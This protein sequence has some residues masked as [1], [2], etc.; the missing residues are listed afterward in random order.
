MSSQET[1]DRLVSIIKQHQLEHGHSKLP[2]AKLA[3]AAG[4]SR[5][6][7]NRYYGDLK[8]YSIGKASIARLFV[9]DSA[10][11]NELIENKDERILRLERELVT[12]RE[13]HKAELE[14]IVKN[15]ISTLMNTDIMAFEASQLTSTLINQ[16]NH[17]AYLNKRVTE[18]A[19][20]NAKLALDIVT[21]ANSDA[22]NATEKSDKNFI[23]FGLDLSA[24][25]KAYASSKNFIGYE[26]SKDE[27]LLNTV[28]KIKKFPNPENIDILFFQEKY[29]S[30]F[31][32]F[33]NKTYPTKARTLIVIRLPL[34]SQEEIKI[35][36]KGLSPISSFSIYVPYSSSD[37][38]ISAKRQFSFR[39]VPPEEITDADNAK[40]PSMA[41]GFESIHIIKVRQGD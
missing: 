35:L 37:A 18:L 38:T 21:A 11:L 33:C 32:V 23:A 9:D 6:A 13:T 26:K 36:M 17:N 7:F 30:D 27:E 12:A 20:N 16:G 3:E 2:V 8:D 4:I 19:V 41:W 34:Y 24:A 1:R 14:A 28:R 29:I 22:S 31:Q 15:H 39:D 25:S 10:S 5:Q 40:T